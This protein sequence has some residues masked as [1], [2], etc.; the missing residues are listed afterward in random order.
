MNSHGCPAGG[1]EMAGLL[2]PSSASAGQPSVCDVAKCLVVLE[3]SERLAELELF[4]AYCILFELF[5]A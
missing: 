5:F 3:L 1:E 2:S 4:F